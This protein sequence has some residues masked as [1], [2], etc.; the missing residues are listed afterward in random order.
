MESPI[1]LHALS[2]CQ[3]LQ[4]ICSRSVTIAQRQTEE[5]TQEDL[6][7][8]LISFQVFQLPASF[9]KKVG[10]AVDGLRLAKD[11]MRCWPPTTKLRA[12]LNVVK[13]TRMRT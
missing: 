10:C 4:L 3:G 2:E 5:Q 13:P 1:E 9:D 6:S 7:A 12:V 11:G 8:F